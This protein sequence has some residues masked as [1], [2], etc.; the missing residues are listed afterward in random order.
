MT[1][2][3]V[4]LQVLSKAESRVALS[5]RSKGYECFLPLLNTQHSNS[6]TQYCG[7]PLFPGYVFCYVT[8]V[9]QR[10]TSGLVVT[11]P[12]VLR[13]VSF[14]HR[15][16]LIDESEI[17]GIKQAVEADCKIGPHPYLATG[18]Q[19]NVVCGPPRGI[20]GLLVR[21]R[22]SNRVV[23]SLDLLMGSMFVEVELA[24]LVPAKAFVS[25]SRTA[26]A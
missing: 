3:W 22:D 21:L 5:L 23:L 25:I 18:E 10:Q 20:S 12:G 19:V 1:E 11:T 16:A 17:A 8:T 14:G 15:P 26:A 9:G 6:S 13:V 2:G 4:A 24:D 7:S